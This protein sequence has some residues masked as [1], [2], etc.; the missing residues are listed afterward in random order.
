MSLHLT[1]CSW[2]SSFTPS[3][4]DLRSFPILM[5]LPTSLLVLFLLLI[6][7]AR[8]LRKKG[9]VTLPL[10]RVENAVD[11]P[12]ELRHQ[13][14]IN[15]AHRI[16]ARAAGQPGPTDAQL[17]AN[18]ERRRAFIGGNT[19]RF[20]I[21]RPDLRI[22]GPMS[23]TSNQIVNLVENEFDVAA[24][25]PQAEHS[26]ALTIDG[27][28]TTYVFTVKIGSPGRDFNIIL[29]S[30][31]GDFWVSSTRCTSEDSTGCGNHTFLG[32]DTS[33]SLTP[34]GVKW[35]IQYGSG[36][37]S[38]E[39]VTDRVVVGGMVIANHKFGLADFVSS[40]F[41]GS[42]IADGLM[43]L[44]KRSL[45]N[46][47]LPTP[48][49]A[50]R[51]LGFFEAAITSYRLPRVLDNNPAIGSITFGGLDPSRFDA[52]T[53]VSIKA[54]DDVGFWIIPLE[55]VNVAGQSVT[56]T[57]TQALMDTGT[58]LLVV[59]PSDADAIHVL[60][61]GSQKQEDHYLIPCNTTT[62]VALGFG[63]RD[64]T[65][66]SRDLVFASDG[67][68]TGDC[69]SGIGFFKDT[70]FL[71]D[72]TFLVGATFLKSVYMSTNEDDNSVTLAEAV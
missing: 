9:L 70:A 64:F 21:P 63:G 46:Q 72:H 43:G 54:S 48:V 25:P 4:H 10:H 62:S 50:L 31:S 23:A 40:S 59:P 71:N 27:P 51:D 55:G 16:I 44:G 68:T 29:D 15:R 34:T 30:G 26:S 39:I 66:N 56:L 33:S 38:G 1:I 7:D 5:H 11:V 17:R 18:L 20:N 22:P 12:V 41:S 3:F 58:T 69:I 47:G 24:A 52:S 19:K 65:I 2:P 36:S 8:P 57:S 28:D 37:A 35:N 32:E 14:Q 60:I 49:V 13:Q 61:P 6:V 45:S 67:R 42:T 53:Q